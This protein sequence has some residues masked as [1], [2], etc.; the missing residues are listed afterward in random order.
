MCLNIRL[1][2]QSTDLSGHPCEKDTG[3]VMDFR[4]INKSGTRFPPNERVFGCWG[5][6]VGKRRQTSQTEHET[7]RGRCRLYLLQDDID[8]VHFTVDEEALL[9]SPVHF[10]NDAPKLLRV[11]YAA[12]RACCNLPVVGHCCLHYGLKNGKS[13]QENNHFCVSSHSRA[14]WVLTCC[15]I[16]YIQ[17]AYSILH[18]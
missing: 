11:G 15:H 12:H 5:L 9:L 18:K 7:E 6:W 17:S 2:I 1:A 3:R 13:W 14:S 8:S 16:K 4:N 10:L